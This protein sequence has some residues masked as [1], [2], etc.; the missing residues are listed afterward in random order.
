MQHRYS[1]RCVQIRLRPSRSLIFLLFVAHL[2]SAYSFSF[3]LEPLWLKSLA[4][5]SILL[6]LLWSLRGQLG[7]QRITQL[8]LYEDGRLE[9]ERRNG[10]CEKRAVHAETTVIAWLVVLLLSPRDTPS[11]FKRQE[12]LVILPDTLSAEDFR[13]LRI[14][15]RWQ[16]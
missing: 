11:Y 1:N 7:R 14:W 13:Q 9:V 10:Q 16:C 2:G 8:H 6:A 3:V 15:L 4:F 12:A 5:I